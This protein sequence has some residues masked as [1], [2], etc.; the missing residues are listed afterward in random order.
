MWA[1]LKP[2]VLVAS[3]CAGSLGVLKKFLSP[4]QIDDCSQNTS[5]DCA[6]PFWLCVR[7]AMRTRWLKP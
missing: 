6:S 4:G 7:C 3:M 5:P 2:A 1:G